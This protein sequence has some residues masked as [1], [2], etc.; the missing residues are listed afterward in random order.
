MSQDFRPVLPEALDQHPKPV[1]RIRKRLRS[2]LGLFLKGSYGFIGVSRHAIPTMPP[3]KKRAMF[4][5]R[6]P[7]LIREVLVRRPGDFPKGGVMDA[8]LRKL[9]G[10]SI[11][12]SNGEAWARHRRI[13][14]QAFTHAGVRNVFSLMRDASDASIVRLSAQADTNEAVAMDEEMTHFAGDIIFRTIYSEPLTSEDA[15]RI[16]SAFETFQGIAFAQGMI[17]LAGIPT[18]WIWSNRRAKKMAREIRDVLNGPLQRRMKAVAAGEPVP[19]NDILSALMTAVD[20]VTGTRFEGDELLDQIAMLF[21]AGH[22]TSA[23][24]LGWALYLMSHRRDIQDEMRSE[25]RA[26]LGDRSPEFQDMKRLEKTRNVF[27][28]ALRLYPPVAFFSRDAVKEERLGDQDI[29]PGEPVVVPAWLMHRHTEYWKDANGFDP[30][31]F[32]SA[33]T[34]DAQRNAYMPFSMGARVCVGAAFALQEATLVLAEIIRR[35][36]VL[37]V[38]GHEP[39]PVSRLT[40]RSEN[41]IRVFLRSVD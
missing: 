26:V 37:P 17:G 41:G 19:D 18:N 31:R 25:A 33:E 3:W 10:Y 29:A 28:E 13:I 6:E 34:R 7:D 1:D 23:A 21:L 40:V 36:E 35:F 14:D 30:A 2:S 20:P 8:M 5:V 4:F 12:V 32:S 24:A 16:F 38:P 22:E 27:R 39:Q 15:H 9:T 11:F